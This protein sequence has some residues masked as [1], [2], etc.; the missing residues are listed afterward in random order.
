MI[1]TL[2]SHIVQFTKHFQIVETERRSLK[3]QL[4]KCLH[5]KNQLLP[6]Q[7][8]VLQLQEQLSQ[9]HEKVVSAAVHNKHEYNYLL[10]F[11]RFFYVNLY[12]Y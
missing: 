10:K 8:M 4:D 5:E 3:N 1:N 11:D 6:N 7:Q 9:L 2:Q 12:A